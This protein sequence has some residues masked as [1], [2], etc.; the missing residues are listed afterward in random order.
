MFE[1]AIVLLYGLVTAA[2]VA[3][4]MLEGWTNHDGLTLH[5]LAG[6][7]ACLLW[8]LTLVVFVLH[9]CVMRLLTRLSRS[10]A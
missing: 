4:T 1:A 5:R 3:V 2:A 10:A 7:I 9:G 8:P 6:L